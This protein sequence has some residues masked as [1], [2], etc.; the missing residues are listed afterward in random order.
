[1]RQQSPRRA[2]GGK[3]KKEKPEIISDSPPRIL[4]AMNGNE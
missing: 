1:M 4:V 3:E 2:S